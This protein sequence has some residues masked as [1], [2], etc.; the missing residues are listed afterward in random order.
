MESIK[1]KEA[2]FVLWGVMLAMMAVLIF[3]TQAIPRGLKL[4]RQMV[5]EY[6]AERLL[7]DIRH[8]QNLNRLLA[9]DVWKYG[10][11]RPEEK[12]VWLDLLSEG[13]T[14]AAGNRYILSH[15]RYYPGVHVGKITKQGNLPIEDKKTQISFE[16][17]GRTLW[18][19]DMGPMTLLV[20]YEGYPREGRRIIIS[21]GGRI[22]MERGGS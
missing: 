21:K 15:R 10:A 20:Y 17:N 13:N 12:F 3:S 19:Q 6:E 9:E 14:L 11:K 5:V 18:E 8:C 2:G 1:G 16:V 7:A 22:R 4:Y